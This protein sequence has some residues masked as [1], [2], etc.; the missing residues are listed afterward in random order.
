M[1]LERLVKDSE[2][3]VQYLR[4]R[5]HKDKIVVLGFSFGSEIGALLAQRHPEWLYAYVGVG[6]S[7]NDKSEAYIYK[8]TLELA[9]QA[10]NREAVEELRALAPYPVN[11]SKELI[12]KALAIRRWVRVFNGGW[13]GKSDFDLYFSLPEWAP[14][15]SQADVDNLKP[16]MSWA[17]E[18]LA[19]SLTSSAD[20][21]E[22][23]AIDF[24]VPIVF[25]MGRY[26]LHTPYV[27][28]EEYFQQIHAPLKKFITFERSS[29]FVMFEEPGRFLVTLV[30]DVLPLTGA[31]V[32]FKVTGSR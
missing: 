25:I 18:A 6:Q 7:V 11:D 32:M 10:G 26:D 2:Q 30:N 28:A 3:V 12:R 27:S 29:H 22:K 31:P 16:G 4:K 9:E 21:L 19:E 23:V 24:K 5:L 20:D 8:R 13:Y 1:S 14:E 15:Y 17:E